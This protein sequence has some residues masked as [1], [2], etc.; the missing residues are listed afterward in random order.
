MKIP[1][2][3]M[4]ALALVSQSPVFSAPLSSS[5]GLS[6]GPSTA[7]SSAAL[8]FNG[9]SPSNCQG[10]HM[11]ASAP[12]YSSVPA[13]LMCEQRSDALLLKELLAGL[14]ASPKRIAAQW[15]RDERGAALHD[16][17]CAAPEYYLARAELALIDGN[18][19]RIA[20]RIGPS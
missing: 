7:P 8:P 2:G 1:L 4:A 9:A 10:E 5:T 13:P 6:T 3:C 20:Q 14:Q 17:Q 12:A 19:E 15:S 11:V 18:A 16:R